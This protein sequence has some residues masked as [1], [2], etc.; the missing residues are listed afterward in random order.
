ME[1]YYLVNTPMAAGVIKFIIPFNRQA[2]VKNTKL[3]KLKIGS[4]IYLIIQTRLDIA[5]RVS[6]LLQFLLNP[7]L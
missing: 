6:T 7:S 4:L 1:N 3:Y 2:T 5:Y